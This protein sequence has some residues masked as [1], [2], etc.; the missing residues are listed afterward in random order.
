[1]KSSE[2]A[3]YF[4]WPLTALPDLPPDS[5]LDANR[6]EGQQKWS[7]Q[8]GSERCLLRTAHLLNR[9]CQEAACLYLWATRVERG[10]ALCQ[11]SPQTSRYIDGFKQEMNTNNIRANHNQTAFRTSFNAL[12]SS[13]QLPLINHCLKSFEMP[14]KHQ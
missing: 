8:G 5:H 1:M 13:C 7:E 14:N 6:T 4:L 10:S 2:S 12:C 11:T 3:G 9:K